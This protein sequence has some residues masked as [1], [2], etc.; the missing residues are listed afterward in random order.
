MLTYLCSGKT[1]DLIFTLPAKSLLETSDYTLTSG[2]SFMVNELS[3]P[4][5]QSTSYSNVPSSSKNLGTFPVTVGT[6]DVVLSAPC[7]AGSTVS[8]E[9]SAVGGLDIEFFVDYNPV[10]YSLRFLV[11]LS[12]AD[13]PSALSVSSSPP[14]KRFDAFSTHF[15]PASAIS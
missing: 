1:C 11:Y 2:G 5:T 12:I 15:R 7:A 6:Q 14:H 3:S 10:S 9:F 8:Y 4:A 13:C